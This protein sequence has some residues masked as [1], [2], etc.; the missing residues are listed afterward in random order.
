M[1]TKKTTKKSNDEKIESKLNY[2][3][4]ICKEACTYVEYL[5]TALIDSSLTRFFIAFKR[6]T[7]LGYKFD[8]YV[9][10]ELDPNSTWYSS[11]AILSTLALIERGLFA[12]DLFEVVDHINELEKMFNEAMSS[13]K[14]P[15]K[16]S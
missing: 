2:R 6:L 7:N 10:M 14:Q 8:D 4:V 1:S 9:N 16:E 12:N 11:S 5:R 3:L 13:V 15:T